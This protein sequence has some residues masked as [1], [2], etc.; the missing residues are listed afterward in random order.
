M[1]CWLDNEIKENYN[2]IRI[3]KETDYKKILLLQNMKGGQMVVARY[4]AE[5]CDTYEKL[6]GIHSPYLPMIYGV[7]MGKNGQLILE[8][9]LGEVTLAERLDIKVPS[10]QEVKRILWDILEG[11]DVLHRRGLVHRDI[12]PDNIWLREAG[13]VLGDLDASR[14]YK[15]NQRRDT[16]IIGTVG[17][18]APEQYGIVQTDYKADIYAIGILINVMLT[19]EHPARKMCGGKWKRI[20]EKCVQ[21]SPRKRYKSVRQIMSKI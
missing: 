11:V 15:P 19:G 17:Y 13:A 2:V 6:L 21:T 4:M 1:N 3:L 20:V 16:Q 18:A 10:Q 7:D 12:K 5:Y 14:S 8:E 9:Y